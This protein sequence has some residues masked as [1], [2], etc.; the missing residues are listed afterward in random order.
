MHTDNWMRKTQYKLFD[1]WVIFT[2][3]DIGNECSG[4]TPAYQVIVS[5]EYYKEEFENK[6]NGNT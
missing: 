2:R 6:K 3:E 5:P 4:D 1:K